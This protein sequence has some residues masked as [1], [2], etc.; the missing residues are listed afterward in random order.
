MTELSRC[1]V[2][3]SLCLNQKC[4]SLKVRPDLLTMSFHY[5]S[6]C[7]WL[8]SP[9]LHF[10]NGHSKNATTAGQAF[11]ALPLTCVKG[12]VAPV[13]SPS[14]LA[15]HVSMHI[16]QCNLA[17]HYITCFYTNTVMSSGITFITTTVMTSQ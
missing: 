8:Q 9:P 6:T 3:L 14:M 13:R 4:A 15:F 16:L 1:T 10:V 7:L 2:E 17:L 5:H 12:K 11:E